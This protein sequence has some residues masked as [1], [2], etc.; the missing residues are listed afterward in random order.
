[1]GEQAKREGWRDKPGWETQTWI[2][3][4]DVKWHSEGHLRASGP[5]PTTSAWTNQDARRG[6]GPAS[7]SAGISLIQAWPPEE[8]G[9]AGPTFTAICSFYRT[10]LCSA[11]PKQS[12]SLWENYSCDDSEGAMKH[13]ITTA[14]S[15]PA[16]QLL[17]CFPFQRQFRIC[18]CALDP[19]RLATAAGYTEISSNLVPN[20]LFTWNWLSLIN[21]LPCLATNQV[22]KEK[23][24]RSTREQICTWLK[25][26]LFLNDKKEVHAPNWDSEK[27]FS[28]FK[29][30]LRIILNDATLKRTTGKANE[31]LL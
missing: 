31:M 1:M 17:L 23:K 24:I 13:W 6:R 25:P 26:M 12:P 9:P 11:F 15:C 28:V 5:A 20:S 29:N 10:G 18:F 30:C 4:A 21:A 16:P 27:A 14:L 22:E 19:I 8:S 7:L 2:W 3:K